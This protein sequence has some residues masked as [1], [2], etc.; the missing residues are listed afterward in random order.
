MLAFL[1]RRKDTPA[2]DDTAAQNADSDVL[3][4]F[5]TQG[6]AQVHVTGSGRYGTQDHH[7]TCRGCDNTSHNGIALYDWQ[8]RD[9]ANTHATDCRA[10]PKPAAAA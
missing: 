6:G 9:E 10:M 3:M 2:L 1:T 4:R 8:A 7:W 5:L